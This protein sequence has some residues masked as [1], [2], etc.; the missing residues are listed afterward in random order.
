MNTEDKKRFQTAM[1]GA[2]ETYSK[3]ITKT[4]L[5]IY[6]E[7]LK[8]FSIDEVCEAFSRHLVCPD[9]GTFFPK[10]ADI[11]RLINSNKP[12]PEQMAELAWMHIEREISRIGAY[13]TLK[14]EDKQALAAVKNMGSWKDLCHMNVDKLPWAKKQF[15]ENYMTFENT[16]AEMLPSH[17]PGIQDLHNQRLEMKKAGCNS[18]SDLMAKMKKPAGIEHKK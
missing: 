12:T 15:I 16:P 14:M 5:D 6:F 4:L 17:L 9:H 2:G 10:P 1:V 13:G 7:S 18:L 11:A 8:S 3:Q